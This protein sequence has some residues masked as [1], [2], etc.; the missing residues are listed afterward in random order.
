MKKSIILIIAILALGFLSCENREYPNN[1]VP[2]QTDMFVVEIIKTSDS[3]QLQFV[4]AEEV[5][6]L[7]DTTYSPQGPILSGDSNEYQ[8]RGIGGV[9]EELFLGT[10]PYI[11]LGDDYYL[12]D[13]KWGE[14]LYEPTNVLVD[15]KW[16]DVMSRQQVWSIE[17]PLIASGFPCQHNY[18]K[19]ETIDR[20]LGV[21]PSAIIDTIHNMSVDYVRPW[22]TWRY[23]TLEDLMKEKAELESHDFHDLTLESYNAEVARQ[24]SLQLV[25]AERLRQMIQEGKLQEL[26]SATGQRIE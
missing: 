16:E 11:E 6:I 14:F 10:N 25:Y 19:R 18:L 9:Y 26:F 24:D 21:E 15:V 4:V 23:N 7:S 2:L 17:T 5:P 1:Y 12:V 13:W 20:I 22:F 3:E 8:I